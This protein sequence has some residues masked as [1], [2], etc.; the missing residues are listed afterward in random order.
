M[1]RAAR[2]GDLSA[3]ARLVDAGAAVGWRDKDGWTALHGAA[4][5]GHRDIVRYLVEHGADVEAT[6]RGGPGGATAL[7]LSAF[8]GH[9]ELVKYLVARGANLAARE[10]LSGGTVLY[11]AVSGGSL[12][13]VRYLVEQGADVSARDRSGESLLGLARLRGHAEIVDYL[14]LVG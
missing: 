10:R 1:Y 13:V 14:E 11:Y 6:V 4:R 5:K 7:H 12:A 3:V 9:L 8:Y 2:Q